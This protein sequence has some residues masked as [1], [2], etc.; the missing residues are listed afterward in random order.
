MEEGKSGSLERLAGEV[1]EA[2]DKVP[3]L[4]AL[5]R[6]P[7]EMGAWN[8]EQASNEVLFIYFY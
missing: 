4:R 8:E 1:Q 7:H 3:G 2:E 6:G 5:G